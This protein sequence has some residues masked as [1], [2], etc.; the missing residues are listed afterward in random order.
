M[1][2]AVESDDAPLHLVLGQMAL[3]TARTKLDQL[4]Q[5]LDAWEQTSL[6]ADFPQS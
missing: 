5:E 4:R 3:N 2:K 6:G 1:I